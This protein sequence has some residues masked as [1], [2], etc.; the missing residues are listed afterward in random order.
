MIFA[1]PVDSEEEERFQ[2]QLHQLY[3]W[4][5]Q[6][7]DAYQFTSCYPELVIERENDN[8]PVLATPT[9]ETAVAPPAQPIAKPQLVNRRLTRYRSGAEQVLQERPSHPLAMKVQAFLNDPQ[10]VETR[11]VKLLSELA[12]NEPSEGSAL[13]QQQLLS[14]LQSSVGYYLDK[15]CF[16]GK[17]LKKIEALG[18]TFKELSQAGIDPYAVYRF[19]NPEEVQQ[20]EP[21]VDVAL[22]KA[23]I[24]GTN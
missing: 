16:N 22:I 7:R 12:Q 19:W 6:D 8:V 2:D 21:G 23:V 10:P 5:A 13:S 3:C 11:T 17:D 4:R 18:G 14:L 20:Y 24:T 9:G 15:I 1:L